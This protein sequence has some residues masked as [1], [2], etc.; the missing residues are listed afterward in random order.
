MNSST[1]QALDRKQLCRRQQGTI[2]EG[3]ASDAVVTS[4]HTEFDPVP[5]AAVIDTLR[6]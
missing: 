3:V 6:D 5:A 1:L 4:I 2:F